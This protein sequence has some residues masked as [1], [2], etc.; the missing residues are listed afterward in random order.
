[1]LVATGVEHLFTE[2]GNYQEIAELKRQFDCAQVPDLARIR[3]KCSIS[4]VLQDYLRQLP[5]PLTTCRLYKQF[6]A[7]LEISDAQEQVAALEATIA[8]L[9]SPNRAVLAHLAHFLH[10]L[11]MFDEHDHFDEKT[12]GMVFGSII[13]G[14]SDSS[15]SLAQM[16]INLDLQTQVMVALVLFAPKLFDEPIIKP[17]PATTSTTA[18]AA[19]ATPT[20]PP[21]PTTPTTPTTP[22]VATAAPA[23]PESKAN[24]SPSSIVS[25]TPSTPMASSTLISPSQ[26][27]SPSRSPPNKGTSPPKEPLSESPSSSVP[28]LGKLGR[29]G[30]LAGDGGNGALTQRA[31]SSPAPPPQ[32]KLASAS[33]TTTTSSSNTPS[34][35]TAPTAS[36]RASGSRATMFLET[37]PLT[38]PVSKVASLEFRAPVI[39]KEPKPFIAP[40]TT[41][42]TTASALGSVPSATTLIRREID[43]MYIFA[44]LDCI[45][46]EY[47]LSSRH[48]SQKARLLEFL[49]SDEY[50]PSLVAKEQLSIG[51]ES[52]QDDDEDEDDDAG[53]ALDK[54]LAELA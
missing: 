13:L 42:T 37:P 4:G 17:K 40:T 46:E 21:T 12:I 48:N 35:P 3:N 26:S 16:K 11:V 24:K 14:G 27:P 52:E 22:P 30:Q 44:Q 34:T 5:E 45:I 1:L 10:N 41:T 20:T 33:I 29:I 23:S 9:P 25:P 54:L 50:N 39:L 43:E 19:A 15:A 32:S 49:L 18:A 51:S 28:V 7:C 31:A 47:M 6:L 36:S 38:T 53:E 8:Q 2:T